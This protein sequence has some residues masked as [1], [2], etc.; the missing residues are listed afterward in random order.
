VKHQAVGTYD[1]PYFHNNVYGH[2]L[3]L[4]QRQQLSGLRGKIHLDVGCGYGRIAEPLTTQLGMTYVGVDADDGGLTSLRSRDFEAHDIWLGDEEPT[5]EALRRVVGDRPIGSITMLDTL[6]HLIDGD[7]VLRAISRLALA[8]SAVVIISVPNV[9]HSDIGLKLALGRWDYTQTGLLDHTH[10]KL[11]GSDVLDRA[12]RHAGLF[13]VA[14]NDVRVTESDQHFPG[15]HPAIAR[16]TQ[17]HAY[18][19]ELRS[20]ANDDCDINQFVRMCVPSAPADGPAYYLSAEIDIRPFLTVVVRTQGKRLHTFNEVLISLAGQTD[21]DFEVLVLG[22]RLSVERQKVVERAIDDT[23]EWFRKKCQLFL[24]DGGNRT[25]PLNVGFA[26]AKG[27]YIAILDDDDVP[28]GHWVETFHG[29]AGQSPGR[30]LRAVAVRQDVTNVN[31]DGR[32]GLRAVG[33]PEKM[34]PSEFDYLAHLRVNHTP[35][36]SVAFPRGVFHDLGVHFDESL[37]TTED[38]DYIMRVAAIVGTANSSSVTS[39]YRWWPSDESSRT[40]HAQ[41]EWDRNH[42]RILQKMDDA[43]IIYPLGTTARLRFL[44]DHF[45]RA[46]ENFDRIKGDFD[47][48][49]ETSDRFN[50]TAARDHLDH[51]ARL[52]EVVAILNS[53]SW[54]ITKPLRVLARL[55]GRPSE[56]YSAVWN[57]DADHLARIANALRQSTSWRITAPIRRLRGR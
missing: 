1:N 46:N 9:T 11:Y 14:T 32:P 5:F 47:R 38:W 34:Y 17:L 25:R 21:T 41:Q 56:N 3:A 31:I 8:H 50:E 37:T 28:F 23:P 15:S 7:G 43:V 45:D 48:L 35:P 49:K 24:V 30:M 54:R 16:G 22:H 4:L 12:L 39:I 53:T 52:R 57:Y 33:P 26:A 27:D 51:I 55:T 13:T 6:E 36:V 10:T 29:L 19:M 42:S 40:V 20:S 44:L 2:A 18:L